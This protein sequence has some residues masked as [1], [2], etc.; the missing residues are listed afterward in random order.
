MV[1]FM[2]KE[3]FVSWGCSFLGERKKQPGLR[4]AHHAREPGHKS[5]IVGLICL[6]GINLN[7]VEGPLGV[8]L[9]QLLEKIEPLRASS[10]RLLEGFC[11]SVGAPL[12][13][14]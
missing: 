3:V 10:Q 9:V 12:F 5:A 1:I 14:D 8:F 13:F 11:L 7:R 2:K 4:E 6:A